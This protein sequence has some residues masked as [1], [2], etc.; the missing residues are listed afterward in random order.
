MQAV[1]WRRAHLLYLSE[2][3]RAA[4]ERAG[5]QFGV[6]AFAGALAPHFRRQNLAKKLILASIQVQ[7]HG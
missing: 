1:L 2:F 6:H 5:K 3:C 7:R 4:V